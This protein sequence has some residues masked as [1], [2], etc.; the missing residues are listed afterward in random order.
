M[1]HWLGD[2]ETFGD[3]AATPALRLPVASAVRGGT[4]SV[5]VTI[6]AIGIEVAFQFSL[7]Y[8][9][10][11]LTNPRVTLGSGG[12]GF[13]LT[14]N[15]L[16]TAGGQ[17]AVLVDRDPLSPLTPGTHHVL[18][19]TFDVAANAAPGAYG[20][21]FASSPI[22]LATSDGYAQQFPM[23]YQNG[24]A[25]ILADASDNPANYPV[26]PLHLE[27]LGY[28]GSFSGAV[29]VPIPGVPG[30]GNPPGG[31]GG[32]G[33]TGGGGGSTG[34]GGGGSTVIPGGGTPDNTI[35]GFSPIMLIGIA[36]VGLWL[37][38]D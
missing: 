1:Y 35:F 5:P 32:G 4:L 22:K 16:H 30:P 26:P 6:D 10:N 20:L 8:H 31:G 2:Q 18:T 11:V 25:V 33:S 34:G 27:P 24:H 12:G 19:I 37:F 21:N 28:Q 7:H 15:D 29:P 17:L 14:V 9:A 38:S 13:T 3:T 23:A 36:A